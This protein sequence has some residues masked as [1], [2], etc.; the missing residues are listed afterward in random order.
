MVNISCKAK[1]QLLINNREI[2][3]LKYLMIQKPLLNTQMIST[4]FV[5]A[6]K[7]TIQIK[8]EKY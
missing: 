6:L 3:G 4:I 5:K 8:Y 2:K 7:N 1:Y